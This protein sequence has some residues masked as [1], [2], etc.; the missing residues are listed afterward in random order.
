[1]PGTSLLP[2]AL[3]CARN[4]RA[5]PARGCPTERVFSDT[6]PVSE[7]DVLHAGGAQRQKNAATAADARHC[8]STDVLHGVVRARFDDSGLRGQM[9]AVAGFGDSQPWTPR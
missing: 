5:P 2:A 6:E 9:T 3:D 1:V 7:N 4:G 8:H